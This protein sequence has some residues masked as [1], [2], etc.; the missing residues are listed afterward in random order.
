MSHFK[1]IFLIGGPGSGKDFLIHS[2]L[3][4]YNLTE[5][6]LEKTFKAIV[7]QNN[8]EELNEFPSVIINGNADNKD[9][10][11]VTKAILETMGYDTSMIYVYTSDEVSKSRNDFRISRGAKTFNEETRKIKYDNSVNNMTEYGEMFESFL[12]FDNSNN[13]VTV[14][15]N[16]KKEITGC[17]SYLK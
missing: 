8:I 7:D 14:N 16:V 11:I 4:E 6:S 5:L 13:F 17:L 1:A 2:V 9:K 3:N 12:L 15:E 10:V